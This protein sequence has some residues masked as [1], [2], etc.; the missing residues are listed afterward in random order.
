[1]YKISIPLMASTINEKNRDKYL[2]LCRR[3]GA[4]RIF[5]ATGSIMLPPPEYMRE[6][7]EFFRSHGYEVGIQSDRVCRLHCDPQYNKVTITSKLHGFSAALLKLY[8]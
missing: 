8:K 6:T 2:E 4:E 3:A 5:L 1:M 7:V